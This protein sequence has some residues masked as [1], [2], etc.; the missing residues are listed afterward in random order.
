MKQDAHS[1]RVIEQGLYESAT[2]D[3]SPPSAVLNVWRLS[4]ARILMMPAHSYLG[5]RCLGRR[6][7]KRDTIPTPRCHY[8]LRH[9]ARWVATTMTASRSGQFAKFHSQ[10]TISVHCVTRMSQKLHEISLRELQRQ[11][12]FSGNVLIMRVVPHAQR[13]YPPRK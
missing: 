4:R 11:T 10:S 6:F 2:T 5:Q 7:P 8:F 13:L 1:T 3:Y 12:L 9:S